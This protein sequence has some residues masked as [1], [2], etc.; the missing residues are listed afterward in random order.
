MK[1]MII[2]DD[3][4]MLTIDPDTTDK[5]GRLV[6]FEFSGYSTSH[7]DGTRYY[8]SVGRFMLGWKDL[9]KINYVLHG[10][11]EC[12]TFS[13]VCISHRVIDGKGFYIFSHF[14]DEDYELS[15]SNIEAEALS[16]VVSRLITQTAIGM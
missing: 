4:A 11:S 16:L 6:L 7:A 1:K 10:C 15:V 8:E 2:N 14:C 9:A 13:G 12:E 5:N 3:Y